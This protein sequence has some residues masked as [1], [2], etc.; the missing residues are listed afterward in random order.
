[1]VKEIT[2]KEDELLEAIRNYKRAYP[3]GQKALLSYAM[4]VFEELIYD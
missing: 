1:M 4:S 3:N 2:E